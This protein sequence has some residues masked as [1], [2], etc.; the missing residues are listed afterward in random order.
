L[1]VKLKTNV[2][3]YVSFRFCA[4]VLMVASDAFSQAPPSSSGQRRI[5]VYTSN[6][7]RKCLVL[8]E[9]LKTANRDFEERSLESV[10]VMAELVMRDIVVLSAPVLEVDDSIY[11]ETQFFEGNTLAVDRLQEILE[12]NKN[13]RR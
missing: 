7:C 2:A 4:G 1:Y 5:V 13:G 12:D 9:W 3:V 6:G 8:K 11:S 10:D